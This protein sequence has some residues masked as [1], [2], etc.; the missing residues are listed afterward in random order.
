MKVKDIDLKIYS[1][2]PTYNGSGYRTI[3]GLTDE[4]VKTQSSQKFIIDIPKIGFITKGSDIINFYIYSND[5]FITFPSWS[6]EK[7]TN[8]VYIEFKK[9]INELE[10]KSLK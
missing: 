3:Y 2:T 10:N 9:V 1:K 7:L 4:T 8:E 6:G 5:K